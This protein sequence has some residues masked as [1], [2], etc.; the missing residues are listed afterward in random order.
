MCVLSIKVPIWKKSGNLSYTLCIYIY[1][2]IY[3]YIWHPS[4][5]IDDESMLRFYTEL[6]KVVWKTSN[7]SKSRSLHFMTPRHKVLQFSISRKLAEWSQRL[8]L[9]VFLHSRLVALS[10]LES[11]VCPVILPIAGEEEIRL[12]QEH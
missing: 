9:L 8:Q 2:Y 12:S 7:C 10:K 5:L 3:I 1:I 11:T 4:V 6:D